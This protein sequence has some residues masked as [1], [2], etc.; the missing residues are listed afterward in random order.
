M[1]TKNLLQTIAISLVSFVVCLG[2]FSCEMQD[3]TNVDRDAARI[4]TKHISPEMAKVRDYVPDM[5][6]VAHRGS[7]FWVPEET[8][9]AWRWARE[10]GA[11]YLESDLQCSKDGVILANHDDNLKRTTN[12]ENVF[13]ETVPATRV[14]FYKKYAGM[15]QAEAEAQ[16]QADRLSFTPF[17]TKSYFYEELM[18][19]DAGT[20]FN[21]DMPEQARE[22]FSTQKQYVST[23]EDQIKY[24]EGKMLKRDAQGERV[25]TLTG[26]WDP[27]NPH[28]CLTY[29]FEYVED[30]VSNGNHPGIYLEFKESWLN[31][32]NFEQM[33]YDE[34]DRLGWN[35]ITKPEP[36]DAP[37]YTKNEKGENVVNVANTNGK[38]ILQTFSWESLRR[39]AEIYKGQ[40]PMCFLLWHDKITPTQY[41]S[42]IDIAVDNLA[43]II[44]PSIAGAP[45]NYFEMNAPWMHDM[46]RRAGMLN[47]P[48][49]F[50]TMEQMHVYFGDWHYGASDFKAPYLDG[51]FTNRTELTLQYMIDKG[52]RHKDAPQ[53]VENAQDCLTRLGY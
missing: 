24:A 45:N 20:W 46:I 25:Y 4:E 13:G 44:G 26:T 29:K 43:H 33:V 42:Y 38:V 19:L 16:V 49:S 5:A 3:V 40:I 2:L 12:I 7:V 37:F 17:Y 34:L 30:E 51:L 15:S 31:P 52:L 9:A 28:T 35:I 10:M 47:H 18:M 21:E 6:V 1:K 8:E 23:L 50:D 32:S 22:A 39:S 48:Y 14:E 11:D 53:T 41:A 27:A 36:A